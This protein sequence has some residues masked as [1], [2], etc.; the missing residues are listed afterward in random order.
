MPYIGPHGHYYKYDPDA[1]IM[2]EIMENWSQSVSP[3]VPEKVIGNF[4]Y[5]HA[6]HDFCSKNMHHRRH[7]DGK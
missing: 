4:D 3:K 1:K 6:Y 2:S 5:P 7:T